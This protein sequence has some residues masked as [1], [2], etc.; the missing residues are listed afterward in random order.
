MK[1]KWTP[2]ILALAMFLVM[3]PFSMAEEGAEGPL[4]SFQDAQVIE[5]FGLV[6]EEVDGTVAAKWAFA[7][8][9]ESLLYDYFTQKGLRTNWS[10][11]ESLCI[12]LNSA[13][14]NGAVISLV[15][16]LGDALSDGYFIAPITLD[17]TGWK[18]IEIP[19]S[20]FDAS[21]GATAGDWKRV[22]GI[23]L[24]AGT[25]A[26]GQG[27]ADQSTVVY[28]D[29]ISLGGKKRI[30]P[31]LVEFHQDDT[32]ESFLFE[33]STEHVLTGEKSA[34][35]SFEKLFESLQ[36]SYFADRGLT[37]DWSGYSSFNM[38]VYN[39]SANDSC[40]TLVLPTTGNL[41][42]Y[43]L[44]EINT[45]WTGWKKISL[46]LGSFS[47]R[48]GVTSWSNI[49]GILFH[50]G[51]WSDASGGDASTTLYFDSI[52]LDG[53]RDDAVLGDFQQ[54]MSG[55][56][57][58]EQSQEQTRMYAQS[59][60][61]A[62]TDTNGIVR[63]KF[64]EPLDLTGYGYFHLWAY[65]EKATGN[66]IHVCLYGNST[67]RD[68]EGW[69]RA[70]FP[71]DWEGGWKLISIPLSRFE[72]RY[73]P[74]ETQLTRIDLDARVWNSAD[75]APSADTVLY[76]DKLWLSGQ[77][78]GDTPVV[79]TTQPEDEQTQVSGRSRT[80]RFQYDHV[81][82][83]LLASDVVTVTKDGEEIGGWSAGTKANE[84]LVVFDQPLEPGA[85]YR[86]VASNQVYDIHGQKAQDCCGITFYT[87]ETEIGPIEI[88]QEDELVRAQVDLSGKEGV[89]G[90][91][92]LAI[93]SGERLVKVA[94]DSAEQTG[95]YQTLEA[96]APMESGQMAKA[97][98]LQSLDSLM[99]LTAAQSYQEFTTHALFLPSIFSDNG[100]LQRDKNLTVWGKATTG[101]TVT[102]CLDE[103]EYTAVADERGDWSVVTEPVTVEG[104]PYTLTVES[105]GEKIERTGLLAG[106]VWL[107]GG[108]S[109][110]AMTLSAA[111][112]GAEQA[113]EANYDGIRFFTQQES[114]SV[115]AVAEDV[116]GGKWSLC[117]PVSAADFSAIGYLFG[118]E[119][120]LDC[121]VPVGL[122]SASVGGSAIESWIGRETFVR[123]GREDLLNLN[124]GRPSTSLYNGM[125][126]PLAPY[127]MR[128]ILWYQGE[129]NDPR[130][131]DYLQLEKML[132]EDWRGLWGENLPFIY[133]QIP[134]YSGDTYPN[135]HYIRQA[136]LEFLDE[137]ENTAMAVF[138]ETGE[139]GNIH[140]ADKETPAHRMALA[141]KAMVYQMDVPYQFPKAREKQTQGSTVKILF[142]GVYDGLSAQGEIT[143]FSICGE[144][145]VYYEAQARITAPD[146]VE[147]SAPQVENP[148]G[149]R[150]GFVQFPQINL[151]NSAGLSASPFCME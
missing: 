42:Q 17:F 129:A 134:A 48:K 34:K 11:Y 107:C 144:D 54:D 53:D 79:V 45:D 116:T 147:L 150:Y 115:T 33:A 70:T 7:D 64:Y 32:I 146:T 131:S 99:P 109:N 68:G 35:W 82:S 43:W 12:R 19:L 26:Q 133:A 37:T 63:K 74:D 81:L 67:T 27:A 73:D 89:E 123:C 20:D 106:D 29:S 51:A 23:L 47:P 69:L 62:G 38:W 104:A 121:S 93:Y 9:F 136:Q 141:A 28:L 84:I 122:I 137:S 16:T 3:I 66:N 46:P 85:R 78:V 60:K 145:G 124:L 83:P 10:D 61:W 13:Q 6:P 149:V 4:I 24:H 117:T 143:G 142:D 119:I 39:E 151:Y 97:M 21:R 2:M 58:L 71:V 140:P 18:E 132:L 57:V 8:H 120:H 114:A 15:I 102:V 22:T 31:Q 138:P 90:V 128:G 36:Y 105:S 65:S 40:F 44:A 148:V 91:L 41:N 113:A 108:Q 111:E 130:Y 87:S 118:K 30:D 56:S 75:P 96:S 88:T 92:V 49:T 139:E 1:M 112:G 125:L 95:G 86:V 135:L 110:M 76:F 126:A 25:W 101:E 14:A 127:G 72:R 98:L 52:W 5:D 100:V 50:A 94:M 55:F 80:V 77:A 103:K 59:A